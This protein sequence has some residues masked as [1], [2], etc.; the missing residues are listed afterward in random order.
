MPRWLGRNR[1]TGTVRFTIRFAKQKLDTE[2]ASALCF[3]SA[4]V[5]TRFPKP[6]PRVTKQKPFDGDRE[7][8]CHKGKR[9][10]ANNEKKH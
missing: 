10:Q 6:S 2:A 9:P 5:F 3:V 8:N 7:M 4:V 1:A